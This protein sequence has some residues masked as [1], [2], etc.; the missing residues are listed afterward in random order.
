[1][2]NWRQ[3]NTPETSMELLT[4]IARSNRVASAQTAVPERAVLKP[5]E[6]RVE[7]LE[8]LVADIP[9]L[10]N[11]RLENV[12]SNQHEANDRIALLDRQI[13]ALTRDVRDTRG[14]VTRQLVAQDAEIAAIK[15][16]VTEVKLTVSDVIVRLSHVEHDVSTIK[17]DVSTLKADVSTLKAD[18]STM[19][20]DVT[21]MKTDIATMQAGINELLSRVPKP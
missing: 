13:A 1:M 5:L 11:L 10:V 2:A 6:Q 19:K 4:N 3:K 7:D 20:F 21:K 15:A 17:A 12:I 9:S 14:G 18:V 16:T 8:D